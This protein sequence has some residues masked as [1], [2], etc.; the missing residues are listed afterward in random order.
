LVLDYLV[1]LFVDGA[2]ADDHVQ[3]T[4]VLRTNPK[5]TVGCLDFEGSDPPPVEMED[6]VGGG[7]VQTCPACLDGEAEEA[8]PSPSND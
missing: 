2:D 3:L 7:Q 8:R 6:M 1:D 5:G 4:F